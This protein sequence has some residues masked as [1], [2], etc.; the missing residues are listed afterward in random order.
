MKIGLTYDLKD[1]Y[2]GLGL[3]AETLAELD[4]IDT[5]EGIESSLRKLG[6]QTERVGNL[7]SLLT[8]L[9]DGRRWDL[10]FNIAEGF[11]GIGREAQVPALLDAF[12]IPYTFSDP[13]VLALTLHKGMTKRVIRDL[14]I[15]TPDFA[16]IEQPRDIA[17]VNLP[18]PLFVKP[19]AEGSGKGVSK[20]SRADSPAGLRAVCEELLVRF[21]QPVLVETYLSGREFT[22]G[23]VGSADNAEV[24]GVMEVLVTT[25]SESGNYSYFNKTNYEGIVDYRLLHGELERTCAAVALQAWRGLGCRDGGRI[26]IRC[27]ESETPHFLE[28][29]P[30]AGLN[31]I[32]SDLPILSRMNGI[33]YDALIGRIIDSASRRLRSGNIA[34]VQPTASF[35]RHADSHPT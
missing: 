25:E 12:E 1:D 34:A 3:D 11:H 30:L 35:K 14:G 33:D 19:V 29:N 7:H 24:T 28:V 21:K 17:L 31:P 6:H 26:D 8:A 2:E 10:V 15:A 13:L 9:Q 18:Y 27:D 23:I 5:I 4:T 20:N 16:V 32:H 22:V